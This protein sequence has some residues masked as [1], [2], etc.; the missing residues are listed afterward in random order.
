MI[1]CTPRLRDVGLVRHVD[2]TSCP[3]AIVLRPLDPDDTVLKEIL[4]AD[5]A[6]DSVGLERVPL[7]CHLPMGVNPIKRIGT[8]NHSA[9]QLGVEEI[10][11]FAGMYDPINSF[12]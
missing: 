1:S 4:I 8:W 2:L 6:K 9:L 5:S 7:V 3:P 10:G 12:V 11:E